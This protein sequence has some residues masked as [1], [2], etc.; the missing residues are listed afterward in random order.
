MSEDD[1]NACLVDGL[2]KGLADL[3]RRNPMIDPIDAGLKRRFEGFP[4][5][6]VPVVCEIF[7][8]FSD[9]IYDIISATAAD[10]NL[11]WRKTWKTGI[12]RIVA[13]FEH[14]S[15]T[16]GGNPAD[17]LYLSFAPRITNNVIT[18]GGCNSYVLDKL[19]GATKQGVL[20]CRQT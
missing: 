13:V 16:F 10:L 11:D 4:L 9:G 6:I 14:F 19:S 5:K 7:D 17:L 2:D 3:F 18:A 8:G 1:A 15:K 12:C 20:C